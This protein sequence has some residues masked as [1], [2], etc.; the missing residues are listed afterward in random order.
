MTY[1]RDIRHLESINDDDDIQLKKDKKINIHYYLN[2]DKHICKIFDKKQLKVYYNNYIDMKH[3]CEAWKVKSDDIQL[4]FYGI[5]SLNQNMDLYSKNTNM[6]IESY[7]SVDVKLENM[8]FEELQIVDHLKSYDI[9]QDGYQFIFRNKSIL[10]LFKYDENAI[11]NV[12]KK[13]NRINMLNVSKVDFN[14]PVKEV[15]TNEIE[16]YFAQHHKYFKYFFQKK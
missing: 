13:L 6:D 15:D 8:M 4:F 1:Y 14:F 12:V 2:Y 3:F 16:Q 11:N 5:K 7:F 10:L 9:A